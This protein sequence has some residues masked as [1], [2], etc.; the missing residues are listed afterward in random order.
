MNDT[1]EET[2][3]DDRPC[4]DWE[5]IPEEKQAPNLKPS[6]KEVAVAGILGLMAF[7]AGFGVLAAAMF[8]F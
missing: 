6:G 4:Y 1:D 7:F 5:N 8:W 3:L 2:F